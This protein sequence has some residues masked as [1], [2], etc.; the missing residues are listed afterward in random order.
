[1]VTKA[2]GY[3]VTDEIIDRIGGTKGLERSVVGEQAR[4]GLNKLVDSLSR[5]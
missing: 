3:I 4:D 2:K 5:S 1:M